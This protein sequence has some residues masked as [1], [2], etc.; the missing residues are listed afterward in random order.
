MSAIKYL[1]FRMCPF[2]NARALSTYDVVGTLCEDAERRFQPDLQSIR[3]VR[4]ICIV[5]FSQF[6]STITIQSSLYFLIFLLTS[7]ST[8]SVHSSILRSLDHIE[9]IQF[10]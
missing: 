9:S 3:G 1:Q 7:D 6:L 5:S 10:L 8:P 2:L 4:E